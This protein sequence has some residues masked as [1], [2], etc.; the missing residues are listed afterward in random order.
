MRRGGL[1]Q[2]FTN[3][4]DRALMRTRLLAVDLHRTTSPGFVVQTLHKQSANVLLPKNPTLRGA[5]NLQY[6]GTI[7]CVREKDSDV[8]VPHPESYCK[9][10]R[11]PP[12][13]PIPKTRLEILR[14][15]TLDVRRRPDQKENQ[16]NGFHQV[17]DDLNAYNAALEGWIKTTASK[18]FRVYQWKRARYVQDYGREEK[19]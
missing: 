11:R 4:I 6:L 9:F 7:Q 16:H 12:H 1:R 15:F 3:E 14:G 8:V 19:F 5:A 10:S 17:L 2:H 18:A 13:K